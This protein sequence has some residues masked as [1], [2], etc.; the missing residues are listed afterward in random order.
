[1]NTIPNTKDLTKEAPR[2][3]Y[4]HLAGYA[5][6]PRTIDKCRA[7]IANTQ[8][9]YHFNCPVD[10][11]LF[12]FK[13]IDADEFKSFVS[14]G[15]S[16]DE[17]AEWFDENGIVKNPE[18][19]TE[20]TTSF[21][22]DFSYSTNDKSEWFKGECARLGLDPESTTLFDMLEEDDKVSFA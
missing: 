7:V 9:E 20:W 16:D 2:S 14:S 11:M 22:S 8:G 19:I 15:H 1:M 5:I 17:I 12:S 18:E 6:L 21:K 4:D 3:P 13:G 10:Q